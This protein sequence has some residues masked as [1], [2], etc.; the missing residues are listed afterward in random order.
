VLRDRAARTSAERALLEL[1]SAGRGPPLEICYGELLVHVQRAAAVLRSKGVAANEVVGLGLEVGVQAVVHQLASWWIGAAFVPLDLALPTARLE[2]LVQDAGAKV[3]VTTDM[4]AAK[5][6]VALPDAT[7]VVAGAITDQPV[8]D[9]GLCTPVDSSDGLCHIA[10]TS[11]STGT[12]K[13]VACRHRNLL[14]YCIG[15]AH[16]HEV[17]PRSRVLLAA[18]ASFDPSI[19]EAYTALLAGATLVLAPRAAITSGL[20][21]V[22]TMAEITHV[23]TTPLLWSQLQEPGCNDAGI[24]QM[25]T[26]LQVVTLGGE[27]VPRGLVQRWAESVRLV[28]VYGTTEG[29]VYQTSHTYSASTDDPACIGQPL[30]G[31][32][33]AVVRQESDGGHSLRNEEGWKY[34]LAACD[35]IGELWTGGAQTATGYHGARL[36]YESG[37]AFLPLAALKLEEN[38]HATGCLQLLETDAALR[39]SEAFWYRTGDL[40][41]WHQEDGN[42][43]VIGRA[44]NQ[45]KLHGVRV[46]LGEVEENLRRCQILVA[47][48]AVCLAT[49]GRAAALIKPQDKARLALQQAEA[50][51]DAQWDR[52]WRAME[53]GL[54]LHCEAY[55]PRAMWPTHFLPVA[56]DLPLGPTH[57]LDRS[58]L[59]QM[60]ADAMA[61]RERR[62][63]SATLAKVSL[64]GIDDQHSGGSETGSSHQLNVALLRLVA[65]TWIQVLGLPSDHPPLYLDPIAHDFGVYQTQFCDPFASELYLKR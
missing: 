35:E 42:L 63:T 41:V 44:D 43:E 33:V 3:V 50:I 5:V 49:D 19:G 11:G 27:R 16:V 26:N 6:Q 58:A 1:R 45:V 7:L 46:E 2:F 22:L 29:T 34:T 20:H 59:P 39:P 64:Y 55:L 9:D 4:H 10:Y 40:A 14:S 32:A 53:Q 15:N 52:L 65:T 37:A 23:C 18:S 12:P 54:R 8:E 31:T 25:F 17:V 48:C 24:D 62:R 13:G 36:A 47:A 21:A 56:M 38:S 60:L 30:P 28:N 61:I 57:K 51:G